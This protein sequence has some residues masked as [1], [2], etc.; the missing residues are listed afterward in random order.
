MA[1]DATPPEAVSAEHPASHVSGG[2]S[3]AS[4][5][6]KNRAVL[7]DQRRQSAR[8]AAISTGTT[9]TKKPKYIDSRESFGG[10]PRQ[11]LRPPQPDYYRYFASTL[12]ERAEAS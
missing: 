8:P 3:G 10:F 11:L 4:G 5:G 9:Q 6:L 2:D 1:K 7:T 12:P